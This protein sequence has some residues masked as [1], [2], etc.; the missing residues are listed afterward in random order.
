MA[1]VCERKMGQ[2]DIVKRDRDSGTH[3]WPLLAAPTCRRTHTRIRWNRKRLSTSG[4][5]IIQMT[6]TELQMIWRCWGRSDVFRT[7]CVCV[8]GVS[9]EGG[10]FL[11]LFC[12]DVLSFIVHSPLGLSTHHYPLI[13]LKLMKSESNFLIW[14]FKKCTQAGGTRFHIRH[15]SRSHDSLQSLQTYVSHMSRLYL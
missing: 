11:A 6:S 13:S 9:Q 8:L 4:K 5:S 12:R 14:F 7:L 15:V 3:S 10:L 1:S 2:T